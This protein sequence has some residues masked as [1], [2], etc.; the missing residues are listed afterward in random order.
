MRM[1]VGL[2]SDDGGGGDV[3][4]AAGGLSSHAA[5]CRGRGCPARALALSL[6]VAILSTSQ[7][8]CAPGPKLLK[9]DERIA[10]DRALVEY[11]SGY[12]LQPLVRNLT[13]ATAMTFD[14]QGNLIIAE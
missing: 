2:G 9:P 10:I 12:T 1:T 5:I 13:G 11:P 14:D 4:G 8:G 6:L 7:T 3:A